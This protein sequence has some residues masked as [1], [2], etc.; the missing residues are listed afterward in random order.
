MVYRPVGTVTPRARERIL[1]A[2]ARLMR[3]QGYHRT[4]L[5]EVLR[6]AGTGKGNFYHHFESKE[7]LGYAIVERLVQEFSI[8]TL[9][10]IFEDRDR[11]PLVQVEA[12]LDAIVAAQRARRCAGGCP[13]GSLAVELSDRHEGFRRRLAA[14]F[15]DWRARLAGA[16]R[17]ALEEGSLPLETDPDR[18]AEFSVAS[19][20]GGILVAR[21]WKDIRALERCVA[22]LKRHLGLAASPSAPPADLAQVEP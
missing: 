2:A 13:L 6:E 15:E 21:V 1:D 22:E 7:E 17:R 19:L 11:P 20:E 16:F 3:E 18:L 8:R 9:R 4:A 5:G 10:P 14:V 12:F